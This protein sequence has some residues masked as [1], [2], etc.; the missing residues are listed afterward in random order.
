[1]EE[2]GYHVAEECS[3]KWQLGRGGVSAERT[4]RTAGT[5]SNRPNCSKGIFGVL[6]F[7]TLMCLCQ[8]FGDI[9]PI[10]RQDR[11]CVV[12]VAPNDAST[13]RGTTA[14]LC[15]GSY[16]V[17]RCF[18]IESNFLPNSNVSQRQKIV[19][20]ALVHPRHADVWVARMI[21]KPRGQIHQN[22]LLPIDLDGVGTRCR[23]RVRTMVGVIGE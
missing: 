5:S 7:Y 18:I 21:Q 9:L 22:V 13:I 23:R 11:L 12:P 17:L 8:I 2:E 15:E 10:L 6:L 20:P 3:M 14:T 1:M 4:D 19:R 16:L